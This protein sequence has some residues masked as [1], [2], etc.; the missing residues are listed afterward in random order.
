MLDLTPQ[1]KLE[2][3]ARKKYTTA[4][5]L[6][7]IGFLGFGLFAI[8]R[9]LLPNASQ[10]FYFASIGSTKNTLSNPRVGNKPT[11]I[12]EIKANEVFD[13]N[14]SR[15]GT[16]STISTTMSFAGKKKDLQQIEGSQVNFRK[17]Y[18]AFFYPLGEPQGFKNGSLL[19]TA[20]ANYYIISNGLLRKFSNTDIILQFGFPK[21]AFKL[22]SEKDLQYNKIG[23]EIISA[24]TYP[25]GSLFMIDDKYYQMKNQ[26]LVPFISQRAFSSQFDPL[27]AITKN[28]DFLAS[29]KVSDTLSIGFADGTLASS[30]QS[31]FILSNGKSYPVANA[32]TFL[33]MG[34]HWEDIIPLQ[35]NEL[36]FYQQQKQFNQNQPHPDG[37]LF[38]DEKSHEYFIIDSGTKRPILS[39][40]IISTFSKQKL[41]IAS[42]EALTKS[43]SCLLNSPFFA[44]STFSCESSLSGIN[45]YPGNYYEIE[46]KF[47]VDTKIAQ[48]NVT[49]STPFNWENLH[50]ALG[51]AKLNVMS[52]YGIQTQ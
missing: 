49:L 16:F 20:D 30:N 14:S 47:P 4:R 27:Q 39:Q 46:T 15:M 41:I 25:D 21:D 44:Q 50:K 52:N 31:V 2:K 1:I 22:I 43:V 13:F 3:S 32:E 23:P 45:Q 29:Q 10:D 35:P 34:F 9:I 18:Q 17:S 37:T 24:N 19:T 28:S 36:G 38:V 48:M 42:Q 6:L 12:G 51:S 33:S 26:Q 11:T 7:H 5:I 8:D 40:A